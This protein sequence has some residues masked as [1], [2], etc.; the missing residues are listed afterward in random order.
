MTLSDVLD[1]GIGQ[2]NAMVSNKVRQTHRPKPDSI[3]LMRTWVAEVYAALWAV[4]IV[5]KADNNNRGL[6]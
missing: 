3:R 2:T 6:L 4:G 1:K 5:F